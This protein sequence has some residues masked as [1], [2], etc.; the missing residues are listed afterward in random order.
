MAQEHSVAEVSLAPLSDVPETR[1]EN[2]ATTVEVTASQAEA[3]AVDPS[4]DIDDI[5]I[6]E[7]IITIHH[8]KP[9]HVNFSK[10]K[11]KGGNIEVLNHFGYIDNVEWV[12]LGDDDL[13]PTPKEDKI[14]FQSFLKAELRFSLHK[15]VVAVF[16]RF[17]IYL[18]QPTPNTIVRLGIFLN[19]GSQSVEPDAEAF[20]EAFSQIHELHFQTKATRGLHNNFG[21]VLASEIKH[22]THHC[23][24]FGCC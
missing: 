21:F 12:R 2:L 9:S 3:G 22:Q 13:V 11:I 17:N 1:V 16:K 14:V 23:V 18:H 6:K 15:T 4:E 5:D 8:M 20:C 19:C 7:D 10:S 24:S